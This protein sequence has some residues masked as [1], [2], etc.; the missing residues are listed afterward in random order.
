MPRHPGGRRAASACVFRLCA[1]AL[2]VSALLAAGSALA[3]APCAGTV[4]GAGDATF[5]TY[6]PGSGACSF[7]GDDG[8]ALVA[9][10]NVTDYAGSAMCGRWLRVTGPLGSVTV[11][12]VDLAPDLPA[13]DIDLNAPAFALIAAP[14]LGRVPVTWE[15]V[16]SPLS[17]TVS[18]YVSPGSNDWWAA[19]QVRHHRYGIASLEFLGPSGYVAAPR[20][21]WDHFVIDG[22][23]GI[24]LPISQP[25]TVR[26]T[27]V[28]GQ[29]LVIPGL[30]VLAG[31][32]FTTAQQFPL[33]TGAAP[34]LPPT[35]G[36]G[37]ALLPPSP[38][39]FNPRTTVA[40][41]SPGQAP[42]SLRVYD[43][44]GRQVATLLDGAV[45]P[46]GRHLA[47]W[48]G[49][50]DAGRPVVGGAYLLRLESGGRVEVRK[51]LLLK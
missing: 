25:F 37:L 33:C 23:L 17:E 4:T 1:A 43:V 2:G 18:V 42:V 6:T 14:E 38:N 31:D 50:D 9:A 39:P 20:T 11:R 45:L 44:A 51:A 48:D 21:T 12:I 7:V 35:V 47:T 8:D 41:E 3:L 10:L 19:L 46:E 27:D 40:F 28:N 26:V 30:R 22:G 5:Y 13:G 34:V 29:H 49:R 32:E 24:P 15:T 16:A 36:T